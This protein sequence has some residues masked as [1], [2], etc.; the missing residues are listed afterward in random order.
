MDGPLIT[1]EW[2]D[3][4][5]RSKRWVSHVGHVGCVTPHVASRITSFSG[6]WWEMDA[7]PVSGQPITIDGSMGEGGGQILRTSLSLSMLTGRPFRIVKLRQNRSKPGLRPQHLAAVQAAAALCD[8]EVKGDE[9]GSRELL[10]TPG[11][12]AP[13]DL[14]VD[15]GTAGATTLVLQTLQLPIALRAKG[16]VLVQ[17]DGGTFN[18]KA[19]S[20]PFVSTTWRD[21]LALMGLSI[22]LAMPRAGFYPRGG[23]RLDAWIEPGMPGAITL[24]DRPPLGKISGTAATCALPGRSIAERLRDQAL[25]RLAERGLTAE[26]E[27]IDMPG[28][29]PGAVLSLSAHHGAIASTFVALGRRG[30]PSEQ[31]A[32]E[33]VDELLAF[34]DS[35]AAVD[36]HS[37]DQILLPLALAEGRSAYSVAAVDEHLRTNV[38]TIGA[39]LD[40]P[41]TIEPPTDS[42]AARVV[43]DGSRP[44]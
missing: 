42:R 40:R 19:P 41:I 22:S 10:F 11:A 30:V 14:R 36:L 34:E 32:D 6:R 4:F 35:A 39:I 1:P 28:K 23:G 12:K 26:I 24:V 5:P 15:I 2:R 31:V 16:P 13:G 17:L 25:R 37:A 7:M 38:A 21:Y 3:A 43:V 33:A 8:A 20:F 18:D 44:R 29:S 27:T 9:V